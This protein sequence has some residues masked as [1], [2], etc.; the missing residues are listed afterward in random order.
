MC[1]RF[2][3]FE[4]DAVLSKAFGAPVA[5]DLSSRYNISPTQQ[6][7]AVRPSPEKKGREA[8]LLQWG[9]IPH[10]AKDPSIGYRMINARS[11]TAAEKPAFRDAFR[12][13]RCLV[14]AGGFYEWKKE[15]KRKQPYYIRPKGGRPFAFAGLWERWEAIPGEAVETCT[16]LTTTPNGLMGPPLKSNA[17]CVGNVTDG[18]E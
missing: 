13:R 9:L 10:W 5:F 6:I 12:K 4:P 18:S 11:E 16:I 2:T 8:V 7:L 14:P 17:T 3:L 1:G 15:E